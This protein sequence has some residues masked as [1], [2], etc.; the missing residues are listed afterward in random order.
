MAG[1]AGTTVQLPE[2]S[3]PRSVTKTAV[4]AVIGVVILLAIACGEQSPTRP[5]P[6]A[7]VATTQGP[8][9]Q[10]ALEAQINGLINALYTPTEQGAV[11]QQFARIKAQLASRRTDDAEASIVTFVQTLL[12]DEAAGDLEDPNG[13]QPPSTKDAL[14]SLVNAVAQFGGLPAPIPPA[15]GND[16]AVA[17]VGPAGGTVVTETGF[18]GVQFPAGALPENVIVVVSRL[19]NPAT[20][21]DGP[22]PTT[23]DQY[24]LFYDFST[25]PPVAQFAQPVLV[26]ICQLEVGA[27]FGPPTQIVASRLQIAHPNPANP[28]TVELLAREVAPFVDCAAVQLAQ[29][30]QR[31]Q[32]EGLLVRALGTIRDFGAQATAVFR[33][34]P[35]YAVH[36]GLGGKT[37][38]FSPFGAVDPGVI[39]PLFG[40]LALGYDHGCAIA[41]DGETYCWGTE[42]NQGTLGQ[43]SIL[44]TV[45]APLKIVGGHLFTEISSHDPHTCGLLANGTAMCWGRSN[46]SLGRGTSVVNN[47]TPAPV[48]GGPWSSISAGVLATCGIDVSNAPWCWG[49]SQR[50]ILGNPAFTTTQFA[51]IPVATSVAFQSIV[52]GWVHVCALTA[53]GQ[54]GD[55]YCWGSASALG[56]TDPLLDLLTPT[57]V[58]S[59]VTFTRLAA[60]SDHTCGITLALVAYCWG[61]NASGQLGDGTNQPRSNPLPVAGNI[62]FVMIALSPV[63]DLGAGLFSCGLSETGQAYCWG[64]NQLGQLGDGT[65]ANRLTPTLVATSQVFVSIATGRDFACAMT[66]NREVFCWGNNSSGELGSGATGGQSLTPVRI[67]S[68]F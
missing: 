20:P 9:T 35:A 15:L 33:P 58:A 52:M 12:A 6:D 26:G 59:P 13:A 54:S 16:Q 45:S 68:P 38:S 60:G 65:T 56:A 41:N 8:A 34:T 4:R 14:A 66:A 49:I 32:G 29:A 19:P 24:P 67:P 25:T 30:R 43:G 37:T 17:V 50:G 23:S 21:T 62:R 7:G 57:L 31:R 22:L 44:N 39:T 55:A 28:A 2:L 63:S 18:G 5:L 42:T 27:P 47:A 3:M 53:G 10:A 46:G 61:Q 51:P 11:V 48:L 40:Q 36:G 1:D 64:D